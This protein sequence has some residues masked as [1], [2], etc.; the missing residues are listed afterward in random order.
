MISGTVVVNLDGF[1]LVSEYL[2]DSIWKIVDKNQQEMKEEVKTNLSGRV[3]KQKTGNLYASVE[4]LSG[5]YEDGYSMV[6]EVGSY[7]VNNN[8][9]Y[10][11]YWEGLVE[12]GS[13]YHDPW[14]RQY[15]APALWKQ[16]GKFKQEIKDLVQK[17]NK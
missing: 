9:P 2:K 4:A 17:I 15:M 3:L 16:A 8:F 14:P 11:L 13:G 7:G 1:G 5:T 12:Q 10:G 6:G